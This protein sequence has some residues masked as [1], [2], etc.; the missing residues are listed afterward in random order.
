MY[1]QG[2]EFEITYL[3]SVWEIL[4]SNRGNQ[5]LKLC[6]IQGESFRAESVSKVFI[7]WLALPSYDV[8]TFLSLLLL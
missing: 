6:L 7:Y 8:L 1:A 5:P 3:W 2:N 4:F